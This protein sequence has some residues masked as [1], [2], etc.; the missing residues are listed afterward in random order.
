MDGWTDGSRERTTELHIA[1]HDTKT[2]TLCPYR[3]QPFYLGM[4]TGVALS[5]AWLL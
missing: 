3:G 4:A 1:T 5:L 2:Q